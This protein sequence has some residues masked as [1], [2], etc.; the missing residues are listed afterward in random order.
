MEDQLASIVQAAV[1]LRREIHSEPEV[2]ARTKASANFSDIHFSK[3]ITLMLLHICL[4]LGGLQRRWH[5][6]QDP[7]FPG[8][9]CQNWPR[10]HDAMCQQRARS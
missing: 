2:Q 5:T 1:A 3:L 4:N 8:N 9:P 6:E 7:V 10:F